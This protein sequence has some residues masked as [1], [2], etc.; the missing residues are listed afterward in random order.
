MLLFTERQT[1]IFHIKLKR[2]CEPEVHIK[3]LGD[4]HHYLYYFWQILEKRREN[5]H[6]FNF[7]SLKL[8]VF[9]YICKILC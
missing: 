9:C 2:W 1:F 4:S 7:P 3:T 5:V 8:E 6:F